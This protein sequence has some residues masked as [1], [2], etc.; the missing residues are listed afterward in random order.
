MWE[1]LKVSIK[2]FLTGRLFASNSHDYGYLALGVAFSAALFLVLWAVGVPRDVSAGLA[3]F[4]GGVLQPRLY[5]N[6][7][8]R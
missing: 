1:M 3:G 8:Y 5:K 2:G 6:L 4:A 7:R